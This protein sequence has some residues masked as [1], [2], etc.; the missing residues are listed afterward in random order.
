MAGN[1][2]HGF[3]RGNASGRRPAFWEQPWFCHGCNKMHPYN[4]F[5]NGT[6]DG[7][8]LCDRQYNKQHA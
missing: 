1:R 8:N 4:R 7:R 5:R 3:R 2:K 6:L